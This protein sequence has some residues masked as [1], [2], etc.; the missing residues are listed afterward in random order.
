MKIILL[1]LI[2]QLTLKITNYTILSKY[3]WYSELLYNNPKLTKFLS[4]KLFHCG[5]C[6]SFWLVNMILFTIGIYPSEINLIFA[7]ITY[8]FKYLQDDE[9]TRN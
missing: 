9:F 2:M 8:F 7:F 1:L 3:S 4:F 6:Q 5:T